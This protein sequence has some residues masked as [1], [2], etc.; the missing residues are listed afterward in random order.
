[1]TTPDPTKV[2]TTTRKD[3][4][5]LS[6]LDLSGLNRALRSIGIRLDRLDA[7]GQ[8]PDMKGRQIKNVSLGVEDR[9]AATVDQIATRLSSD[10]FGDP[11]DLTISGGGVRVTGTVGR[12]YHTIDTEGG[13]ASDELWTIHGGNPGEELIAEP[14]SSARTVIC[15]KGPGLKMAMDFRLNHVDDALH[16]LCVSPSVWKRLGRASNA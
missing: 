5:R 16:L 11:M 3:L 1:M 7:I 13:A 6:V 12:R 10:G 14:K 9:D 4:Y 2:P 15:K 8:D